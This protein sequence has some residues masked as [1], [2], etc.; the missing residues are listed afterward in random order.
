[1]SVA[2]WSGPSLPW[3]EDRAVQ[4]SRLFDGSLDRR[5]P[6]FLLFLTITV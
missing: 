3:F 4:R 5:G 1:M 6:D 2:E